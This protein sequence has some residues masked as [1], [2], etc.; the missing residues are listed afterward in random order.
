MS[1]RM[2]ICLVLLLVAAAARADGFFQRPPKGEEREFVTDR[3]GNTDSPQ[4][5]PP[6]WFQAEID[7]ASYAEDST[8]ALRTRTWEFGTTN[9]GLKAG[10]THDLD[11]HLIWIPYTR[12]ETLDRATG[13]TTTAD[14]VGN[15]KLRAKRNL[16]GNDGG[17]TALA[18]IPAIV[19]P[20][21]STDVGRS[22]GAGLSA[23]YGHDLGGGWAFNAEVTAEYVDDRTAANIDEWVINGTF[24]AGRDL[25]EAWSA[26]AEVY[27]QLATK[28]D[29]YATLDAGVVH[30]V[31]ENVAIDLTVYIGLNDAATDFKVTFGVG[32]RF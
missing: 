24:K 18:L 19:L 2:R 32:F 31:A 26:W 25:S 16:W 1:P 29:A 21:A 22:A 4:T 5:V 27:W 30:A 28:T 3:P 13:L 9:F 7:I 11:V 15:L 20:V 10:L 12:I 23:P 8:A 6:G 14:G 17:K